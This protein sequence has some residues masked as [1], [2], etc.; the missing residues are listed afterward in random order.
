MI[1][2]ID[3]RIYFSIQDM[4]QRYDTVEDWE[5]LEAIAKLEAYRCKEAAKVDQTV[6]QAAILNSNILKF[7]K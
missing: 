2:V 5:K 3:F 7:P 1:Q 4:N 6:E